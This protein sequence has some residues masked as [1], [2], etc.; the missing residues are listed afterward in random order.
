M[1]G[2]RPA[3]LKFSR[4]WRICIL[5]A[6]CQSEDTDQHICTCVE[7][8]QPDPGHMLHEPVDRGHGRYHC[9]RRLAGD[10]TRFPPPFPGC[11]GS[12]THTRSWSPACSCCRAHCQTVSA[13]GAFFKL[14]WFC[15]PRDRCC[16]VWRIALANWSVLRRSGSGAS[17][18]FSSPVHHCKRIPG[19]EGTGHAVGIWG[20]VAGVLLAIGPLIGGAFTEAVGWRSIFWINLPI[21]LTAVRWPP[22][23]F[24]NRKHRAHEHSIWLDN[25]WCL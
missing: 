10:P 25:C 19:A 5:E 16:A 15:S 4:Q 2:S 7:S 20:A 8:P 24:Q 3:F 6:H 23:S 11:N 1:I 17:M 18:L 9:E 21:G 22:G 14:A 12:L 13:G